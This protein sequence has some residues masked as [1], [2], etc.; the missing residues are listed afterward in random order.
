MNSSDTF[1]I[2]I[3]PPTLATSITIVTGTEISD[4]TYLVGS[5]QVLLNVPQYTIEPSNANRLISYSVS[6]SP[7]A[8]FIAIVEPTPRVFKVQILTFDAAVTGIYTVDVTY[9]ENYSGLTSSDTFILT[10]SCVKSL[11]IGSSMSPVLYYISDPAIDSAIPL[12]KQTPSACPYELQYSMT[13]ADGSPLPN[14]ISLVAVSG[15]QTIRVSETDPTKAGVYTVRIK[16]V[17]PKTGIVNQALTVD[18]TVKCTKSLN[19][20]TN[21]IPVSSLYTINKSQLLTTVN[22]VPSYAPFPGNCPVGSLTYEVQLNPLSTPFP[23][24]IT[25]LPTTQIAVGTTDPTV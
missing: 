25:R 5:P 20:V 11:A 9:T 17:D 3:A 24:W 23:A 21:T 10:V 22:S 14:A 15:T 13:L 1:T 12:F 16:V 7:P 19:L 8:D 4:L 18:V 2:T 6:S